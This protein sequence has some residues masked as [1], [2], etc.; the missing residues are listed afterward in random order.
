MKA[1]TSRIKQLLGQVFCQKNVYAVKNARQSRKD[2][3]NRRRSGV[4]PVLPTVSD[5]AVSDASQSQDQ[6]S[7][8]SSDGD[9]Y[10]ECAN[11]D[12]RYDTLRR[13]NRKRTPS[14]W[15]DDSKKRLKIAQPQSKPD[16][17]CSRWKRLHTKCDGAQ[18]CI[19]YTKAGARLFSMLS[20]PRH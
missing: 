2:E 1:K 9:S 19:R 16:G 14:V 11:H 6:S 5:V 18:Q 12:D 7:E 15:M 10:S 3:G 4:A 20:L 17:V 13:S 8:M